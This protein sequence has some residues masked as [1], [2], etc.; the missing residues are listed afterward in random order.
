M[1]IEKANTDNTAIIGRTVDVGLEN[2]IPPSGNREGFFRY[3]RD[4]DIQ[5]LLRDEFR[6]TRAAGSVNSTAA[7]PGPG[8]R[9]VV[10]TDGDALSVGSGVLQFANPNSTSGDPGI[11]YPAQTRAAGLVFICKANMTVTNQV[12]LM[13]FHNA[14]SGRPDFAV[15]SFDNAGTIDLYNGGGF[16]VQNLESYTAVTHWAAIVLKAAG[17]YY[18]IKGGTFTNW[19]LLYMGGNDTTATLYPCVTSYNTT[20][21]W[22]SVRIPDLTWLPTPLA[23]DTFTRANGALG[24][25]ETTGPDSQV[26]SARTWT[27]QAGSLTIQTNRAH[28]SGVNGQTDIAT[29]DPGDNDIVATG[30]THLGQA[31]TNSK[32]GI[33]LHFSDT[34]NYWF[35]WWESGG[36][37]YIYELNGGS[38]TAR[39]SSTGIGVAINTDY[40]QQVVTDGQTIT[41]YLENGNRITYGSAA[42]NETATV[43]G[44]RSKQAGAV[45]NANQVDNFTIF[46]RGSDNEFSGLNKY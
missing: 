5:Y 6:D 33:L 35:T 15:L 20:D 8:T 29:I 43:H 27:L 19:T 44:I 9:T 17:A 11:W 37:F 24:S 38:A 30:I 32:A 26:V 22:D 34:S 2:E 41:A 1:A 40:D 4:I 10:D 31:A 25:T 14:Q 23:Y 42:L 13:G 12:S 21:S 7:T 39:A 18:F 16:L 3:W 28:S 46:P 45:T 36:N